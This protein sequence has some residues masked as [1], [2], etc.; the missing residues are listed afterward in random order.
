MTFRLFKCVAFENGLTRKRNGDT[1]DLR[2]KE[3]SHLPQ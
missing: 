1:Y 2:I 3:V